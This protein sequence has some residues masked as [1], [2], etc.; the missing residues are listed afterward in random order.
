MLGLL[1]ETGYVV[2]TA[3]LYG[4]H[5]P[6]FVRTMTGLEGRQPFVDVVADQLGQPT[7]TVDVAE[8]VVAL[9][10]AAPQ[11]GVYH[12]TSS[13]EAT[14][15]ELAGRG[16]PAARRRPGPGTGDHQ[17]RLLA[18]GAAPRLQRAGHDRQTAAGLAPIGDWRT[19]LNRAWPVLTATDQ[20]SRAAQ[21]RGV[22]Q[23]AGIVGE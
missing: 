2:R 6:N 1:P 12:A 18:A 7:W 19:A 5:G 9:A 21:L 3:W 22:G 23:A 16:L 4:A 10:R 14:W 20:G 13:G 15:Y 11:A 17:R 8:Q